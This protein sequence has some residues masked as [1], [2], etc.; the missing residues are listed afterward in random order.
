MQFLFYFILQTEEQRKKA[1]QVRKA[2]YA[3]R[4][5]KMVRLHSFSKFRMQFL[6]YF[7]FADR[8]AAQKEEFRQE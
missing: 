2:Q 3:V 7:I 1:A 6:F 8:R 4:T 5:A